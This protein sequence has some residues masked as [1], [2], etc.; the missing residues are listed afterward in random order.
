[1]LKI[2]V[3]QENDLGW[4]L[5]VNWETLQFELKPKKIQSNRIAKLGD[6][7]DIIPVLHKEHNRLADI[8]SV[9]PDSDSG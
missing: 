3:N 5:F 8:K 1:M 7:S 4:R 2:R 6:L 9:G